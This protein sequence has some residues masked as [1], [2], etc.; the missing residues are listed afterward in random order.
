M[1]GLKKSGNESNYG[2]NYATDSWEKT[3]EWYAKYRRRK[4]KRET[5]RNTKTT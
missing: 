3:K 4:I 1:G 5:K 2:C